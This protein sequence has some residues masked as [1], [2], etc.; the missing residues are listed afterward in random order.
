M[1]VHSGT[2]L[3]SPSDIVEPS[4]YFI[5]W[6]NFVTISRSDCVIQLINLL[7]LQSLIILFSSITK[8]S[9]FHVLSFYNIENDRKVSYL[10][11][12]KVLDMIFA[13]AFNRS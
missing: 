2:E 6:T 5:K 11:M 10:T 4:D 9:A 12:F 1:C 13:E 7:R 3:D 8:Q